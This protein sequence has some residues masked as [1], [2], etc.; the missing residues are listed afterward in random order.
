MKK[1]HKENL[2]KPRDSESQ[3]LH[4]EVSLGKS[5]K[6]QGHKNKT[7]ELVRFISNF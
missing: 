7:N 5:K 2:K 4:E 6:H 3:R 1:K